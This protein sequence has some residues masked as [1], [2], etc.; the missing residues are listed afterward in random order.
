MRRG[1]TGVTSLRSPQE[2]SNVLRVARLSIARPRLALA[3]WVTI[4]IALALIGLGVSDHLSPSKAVVPGT[5]SARAQQLSDSQFG[6]SQLV[7]VLLEGPRAAVDKQGPE[8]VRRLSKEPDIRVMS[9]WDGGPLSRELRP[10]PGAAMVIA[11]VAATDEQMFDGRQQEIQKLVDTT[12]DKPVTPYVS[13]TPALDRGLAD[14]AIDTARRGVLIAIPIL[15]VLLLLLL[16]APVAAA[17]VTV[18]GGVTAL[19]GAGVV[20]LL[21]QVVDA[22]A[23]SIA[24]GSMT[25]LALGSGYA[26]LI[27]A[28]WAEEREAGA[29]PRTAA[30]TAVDTSG[31]AV[32][33]GG[34]A[35][36]L[37]M[38]VAAAVGPT[39]I[40]TSEGIGVVLCALL[41][42]G[43]AVVV[44]PAPL[45]VLGH[46][47][48]WLSFPA[49][50]FLAAGWDRLVGG[51]ETVVRRAA[52]VGAAAT[53]LLLALAIPVLS[54]ELGPPSPLRLPEDNSARVAYEKIGQVMGPGWTAPYNILIVSETRPLTDPAVLAEIDRLQRTIAKD[55]AVETV[56]GPGVF[57][58][59][60]R[61]LG[62]LP[63][64][65]KKSSKLLK[66]GPKD[67][68]RL[69]NGLGQAGAGALK[70]QSGLSQA[71]AG[72][73]KLGGGSG[74]AEAGAG[75][76]KAGL[77]KAKAGASAISGGLD[78]ALVGA[79][80]LKAGAAS[81]LAGSEKITGGIGQAVKPVKAGLPIVQNMASDVSAS[82]QAVT[83]AKG[84]ADSL[85]AQ[86]DSAAAELKALG[87]PKAAA[88]LAAVQQAQSTA[89]S[90]S[91]SLGTA[92]PKLSGASAVA[93]AFATQVAQLSTGLSQLLA[94]STALQNGLSD[95][96]SGNAQLASGIEQLS[97]GGGSLTTGLAA[98]RDGAG[99]LQTG[100]GQLTTGSGTLAGALSGGVAPAG[101]L[102]GGLATM[103]SGVT[104]FRKKL[105]SPKDLE[106]LQR[107]S[108]GLFDSGYFVLAAIAG[109]SPA[110]QDQARFAVNLDRGGTAGQ[111]LIVPVAGSGTETNVALGNRLR[112]YGDA[113]AT[114]TKT[115]VAIGGQ[116]AQF[117][118]FQDAGTEK[119]WPV[120]GIVALTVALL[121]MALL[122]TVLLPLVA[123]AC[124]LLACAVGFGALQVLFGGEDPLLG[125]PGTFSPIS[126]M[127]IFAAAFG[128]TTM[129]QVVLLERTREDFVAGGD[130]HAALRASLR[131]TAPAATGAAL[132]MLAAGLPF[133]LSGFLTIAQFGIGVLVALLVDALIVRPVLLPAAVE[134]LG[135]RA[136]WPTHPSSAGPTQASPASRPRHRPFHRGPAART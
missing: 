83:A 36:V 120:I 30:S 23:T 24:L 86:L 124:S 126:I 14:A 72:A 45:I 133:A 56:V 98:L 82:S 109:A 15:F 80:K 33:I 25:G 132:V 58:A 89:G 10:E 129:L 103:Q 69:Q 40:L 12:I 90:L 26:L 74:E 64:Q 39:D 71:A 117:G 123:V 78:D 42:I 119:L 65:L 85:A 106:R 81:A 59:T 102:A 32:L 131:E 105:P 28:R 37:A 94:G 95:L 3:L 51:E 7:P 96:R 92:Q 44:M 101:Q 127:G 20:V 43:A 75:Q 47:M 13:G 9:A 87:D 115:E 11:S 55:P 100:L 29:D 130:P 35:L 52:P 134:V 16:R 27:H 22:D 93:G 34:T 114:K 5:G 112:T 46:R 118:D 121:L 68:G 18:F 21:A 97:A 41:G 122:R 91:S 99:R 136:W 61:Q 104:T 128:I 17:V 77:A 110:Q 62:T 113:F 57:A 48:T 135:H 2:E 79:R 6:P 50:R 125:G 53:A 66:S 1:A 108:P 49:P 4:G 38:I 111:I 19:A 70:L 60:S 63:K 8:L 54:L 67:L 116:A 31:R 84:S 73:S 76:L 107:E 88:A